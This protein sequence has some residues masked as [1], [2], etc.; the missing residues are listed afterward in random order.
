MSHIVAR[1]ILDILEK[2]YSLCD[3]IYIS[4]FNFMLLIKPGP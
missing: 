4:L 3:Y 2:I 1:N